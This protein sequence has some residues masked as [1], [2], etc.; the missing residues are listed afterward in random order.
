MDKET[1]EKARGWIAAHKEEMIADLQSFA[2]IRSV[3]RADLGVPGAPFGPEC[4]TMLDFALKRA[5]DMGFEVEDHEGYC[6]SAVLGDGTNAIGIAAHLD[7]VPEGDKWVFPPY[8]ATRRGD[9]LIGRGVS[10]NKAS[11]ILGLYVMKMLREWG[12]PKKHG[13][14]LLM[15]C[16]EETGME[17]FRYYTANHI[18]PKVSLVADASFP[19]NYAQK[20][21]MGGSVTI[22]AGDQ[23][24]SFTG[25]EVPNMVPPY[26]KAELRLS[27]PAVLIETV[28]K[29]F[30]DDKERFTIDTKEGITTVNVQ[31]KAA[32]AA[33]PEAGISAIHL[34]AA[35]LSVSGALDGQSAKA[36]KG[37]A[38]M[39]SDYYGGNAG[40]ACEDPDTGKTTMVCGVAKTEGRTI[41]LS[42]DCRLSLAAA[43]DENVRSMESY[44]RSLGFEPA[45]IHAGAPVFISRDD[46]KILA[47]QELYKGIT[48]D[49][50]APY[51]MGGGT[52]SRVLPNA[53]T[54]G[55]GMPTMRER[56]DFIPED[57]GGAHAP[58]EFLYIPAWLEGCAVYACA[59]MALDGIVD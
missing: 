39:T 11:A 3:S 56:P 38:E 48:G 32:H 5:S 33:S 10:D 43:A 26:A 41:S 18:C 58:D 13:I 27:D 55:P 20:G 21:S 35:L 49:D 15:G 8:E 51:T 50:R 29:D 25:G 57:H 19:V 28:E 17:D 52:Y 16:S 14:R 9:F 46:P 4:R 12:L 2:R 53:I 6:G 37:L 44:A 30:P 59:L 40:I 23:I 22:C 54:Y 47:L 36:A 1:F 24:L 34:L 45:G 7:V 31:G 42:I